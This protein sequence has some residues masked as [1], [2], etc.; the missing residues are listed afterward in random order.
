M[1]IKKFMAITVI[2]IG[3]KAILVAGIRIK[4]SAERGMPTKR[5]GILLP[6]LVFVRS[7]KAPKTGRNITANILSIVITAPTS[8]PDKPRSLR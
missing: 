8:T 3:I 4:A 1:L 5:N 7:L 2:M 6:Y